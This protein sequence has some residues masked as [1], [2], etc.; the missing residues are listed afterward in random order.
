MRKRLNGCSK[1]SLLKVLIIE[2]FSF[3]QG[4][5]AR[6]TEIRGRKD[7]LENLEAVAEDE[8][9]PYSNSL[10]N[11]KFKNEKLF[12]ESTFQSGTEN[13][14]EDQFQPQ[15]QP[16]PGTE[17][18]HEDQSEPQ[19]VTHEPQTGTE[20]ESD[21]QPEN[22]PGI[23]NQHENQFQPQ[24]Q[25]QPGTE[26]QHEDQSE[27]QSVT[28]E[29]QTGT[30]GESDGQ[31]E[32]HPGIENQHENQFQPQDQPQPGTEDQ[33]E[34]QSEPQSVTHEPQ[35]GTEGESDNQ[36]EDQP[37][38]EEQQEPQSVTEEPQSGTEDESDDQPEDQSVTDQPG[39]HTEERRRHINERN[40]N[41]DDVWMVNNRHGYLSGKRESTDCTQRPFSK[42]YILYCSNFSNVFS[43]LVIVKHKLS[44]FVKTLYNL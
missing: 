33:H 38:T 28:H 27:P 22:H 18:Q 8:D 25:P 41:S 14:H 6:G 2:L 16:Q 10:N 1:P 37:V 19:S 42:M 21:G 20:G 32:N 4:F 36:P 3:F 43:M 29:P 40:M 7:A 12:G 31:P 11:Q 26:D 13:Q 30:E 23:E 35:T 24:D 39:N 34:D 15:D 5:E 17:D 9:L 44:S